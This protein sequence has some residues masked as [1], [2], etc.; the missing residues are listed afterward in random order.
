MRLAGPKL[1]YT[2]R[3]ERR[4]ETLPRVRANPR[5]LEHVFFHLLVNAAQAVESD[6]TIRVETRRED[7]RVVVR[8]ADDGRGIR[9]ELLDR[10]FDPF[11]TTKAPGEG[12]GLGLSICH[13]IMK[14]LGGSLSFDSE[15]G[16]GTVFRVRLPKTRA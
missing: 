10:V 12:S 13:T 8:I 15:P 7:D 4:Y 1:R 14:G 5:E 9:P 3:I 2:G 11:F 16:G 6:G